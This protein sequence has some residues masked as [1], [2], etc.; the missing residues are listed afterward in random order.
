MDG[1]E[2]IRVGNV[3]HIAFSFHLV[4][5]F[6]SSCETR[7][8][9]VLIKGETK[10]SEVHHNLYTTQLRDTSQVLSHMVTYHSPFSPSYSCAPVAH[11]FPSCIAFLCS[12]FCDLIQHFYWWV[13]HKPE[14]VASTITKLH[15]HVPR[16]TYS[17]QSGI[18]TVCTSCIF[19]S[20]LDIP[21]WHYLWLLC[22]LCRLDAS[23]MVRMFSA[24]FLTRLRVYYHEMTDCNVIFY[25]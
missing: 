2:Q 22:H 10:R 7:S 23:Q 11:A 14:I 1:A 20:E 17:I 8:I 9:V 6:E 13:W 5:G 16:T 21:P 18:C 25:K 3:P 12:F 15:V 4:G 19:T 24:Q